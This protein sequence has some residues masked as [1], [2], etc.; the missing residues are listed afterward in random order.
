M[1]NDES[2]PRRYVRVWRLKGTHRFC[3]QRLSI[4]PYYKASAVRLFVSGL[5]RMNRI[6]YT[7][8][9]FRCPAVRG[10]ALARGYGVLRCVSL[11]ASLLGG[12]RITST[13]H[14]SY[15]SRSLQPDNHGFEWSTSKFISKKRNGSKER[16][17][18][19]DSSTFISPNITRKQRSKI[20]SLPKE[21][22]REQ[23]KSP[24][25]GV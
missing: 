2:W 8:E 14:N 18:S 9:I 25:N 12:V 1:L 7:V 22:E 21:G 11:E 4:G 17:A 6:K 13:A 19:V 24:K 23:S 15:R 5:H 3:I 16:R 10:G 20:W